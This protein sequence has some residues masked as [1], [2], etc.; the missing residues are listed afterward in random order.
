MQATR[1]G[2]GVGVLFAATVV[3]AASMAADG[4]QIARQG[5]QTGAPACV[6]CH[7]AGGEGLAAAGYPYLA[8]MNQQYLMR[9]LQA[10]KTGARISPVMKP[11]AEALS[12]EEIEAVTAYFAGLPLPDKG[13]GEKG[14][15]P[16]MARAHK[17][18]TEGKWQQA[19]MP[20]CIACH[21]PAGQGVG[22]TF[23]IIVGQPAAYI[24]NQLQA[25]RQGQRKSDP[26]NLMKSVAG[27]LAAEEIEALAVYLSAQSPAAAAAPGQPSQASAATSSSQPKGEH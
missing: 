9:Q 7:G 14:D 25:W 11:I 16:R 19:G 24:E 15:A 2:L 17:L 6:A 5:N 22:S 27:K 20:A 21:G 10:M 3:A 26:N 4:K 18:M 13:L 1:M 8:G 12:Q 23:P